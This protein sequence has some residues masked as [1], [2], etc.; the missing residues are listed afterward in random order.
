[1]LLP[2][3]LRRGIP[4]SNTVHSTYR[5]SSPFRLKVL[6]LYTSGGSTTSVLLKKTD[7]I[8]LDIRGGKFLL[9]P[10]PGH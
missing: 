9:C 2:L 6:L 1:M 7:H 5:E 8:N 3:L 10:G 4:E